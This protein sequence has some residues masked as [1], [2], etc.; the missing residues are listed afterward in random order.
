[1]KV[2]ADYTCDICGES[3]E[4]NVE[5]AGHVA[6]HRRSITQDHIIEELRRV[7]EQKGRKA[8]RD[9]GRPSSWVRRGLP[10]Q[11]RSRR[12]PMAGATYRRGDR[13]RHANHG[14]GA[15]RNGS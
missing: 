14:S 3:F 1:M 13:E 7:A 2:E 9:D 6:G 10:L 5:I 4:T 12:G 8:R 15:L 11:G